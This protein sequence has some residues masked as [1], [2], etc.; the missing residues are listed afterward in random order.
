VVIDNL[1]VKGLSLP[2]PKQQSPL[3]VDPDRMKASPIAA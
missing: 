2:P 1:N 3:I